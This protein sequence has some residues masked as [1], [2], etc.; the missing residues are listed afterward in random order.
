MS[1]WTSCGP[2]SRRC[3]WKGAS[4]LVGLCAAYAFGSSFAF[5]ASS[6]RRD[7]LKPWRVVMVPSRSFR[8]YGSRCLV[9]IMSSWCCRLLPAAAKRLHQGDGGDELLATQRGGGKFDVQRGTLSGC[10]FEISDEPVTV[11]IIN[12][13]KLFA[14][15][16]QGVAFRCVLVGEKRLGGTV[17]FHFGEG[18]QYALAIGS[19]HLFVS[20]LRQAQTCA[21]SSPF[22]ER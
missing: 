11:L 22:E 7:L 14:G 6:N 2:T 4:A 17:V 1:I 10:H 18:R 13:F 8:L 3:N 19:D 12:N 16:D 9:F 21:K 5:L 20:R 15:G